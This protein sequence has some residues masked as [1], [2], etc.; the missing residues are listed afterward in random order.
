MHSSNR[1]LLLRTVH[2]H[3]TRHSSSEGHPSCTIRVRFPSLAKTF[4]NGEIF[5]RYVSRRDLLRTAIVVAFALLLP[6]LAVGQDPPQSNKAVLRGTVTDTTGAVVTGASVVLTSGTG[7]KQNIQ[8]DDKGTYSFT[9][10][11]AGVYSLSVT[12]PDFAPKVLDN[13]TLSS[14]VEPPNID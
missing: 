5:V 1:R 7:L 3:F 2:K 11:D 8:T 10:L 13:I 14:G 12:A 4:V 9:N 6:W